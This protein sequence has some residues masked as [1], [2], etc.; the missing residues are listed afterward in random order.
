MRCPM[1]E[2]TDEQDE[3]M[4]EIWGERARWTECRSC[5]GD[6]HIACCVGNCCATCFLFVRD[7]HGDYETAPA[8]PPGSPS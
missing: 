3:E 7:H 8:Q 4:K 5:G 6:F 1:C 2:M